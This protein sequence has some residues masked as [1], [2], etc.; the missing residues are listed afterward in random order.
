MTIKALTPDDRRLCARAGRTRDRGVL[1]ALLA[2]LLFC[3]VLQAAPYR[4]A[5]V[6][7]GTLVSLEFD[8]A[9]AR[10]RGA[11]AAAYAEMQR[12]SDMMSRYDPH[13]QVSAISANAG[14]RAV[15]VAPELMAVLRRAQTVSRETGGAFDVTVGALADWHFQRT[16]ARVPQA[17]EIDRERH[18]VDYR[19]LRLDPVRGTAYLVTPGMRLD[20]G[21]IAKLYILN[22]GLNVL[23]AH[24]IRRAMING[25]G[26]VLVTGGTRAHPWRIGIRDPRK[27]DALWDVVALREGVVAS[28]GDYE[29][30][31]KRN[32]RRYHHIL[33]PRTGY[34]THG[35][36]AV[37]LVA[38]TIDAVN[39]FGPATMVLGTRAGLALL[40][41]RHAAAV[42]FDAAGAH[43]T[44]ALQYYRVSK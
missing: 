13:S 19:R 44:P 11:A 41:R 14:R 40:E 16:P 5:R 21:G 31:F 42:I 12:L 6:L 37:T 26:D 33:D 18:L 30:Y 2:L 10:P 17:A 1:A 32:G 23:R 38:P 25:G 29:R 22:A 27:P 4:E 7:M 9:A 36:F 15:R 34:P 39:G 3:P 24:G 35:P 20:L 8:A 43:A 28:S